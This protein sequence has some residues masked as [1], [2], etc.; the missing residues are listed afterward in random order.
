MGGLMLDHKIRLFLIVILLKIATFSNCGKLFRILI[1]INSKNAILKDKLAAKP[2]I[3]CSSTTKCKWVHSMDLR[4][5]LFLL[6]NQKVYKWLTVIKD[7]KNYILI[8]FSDL[9]NTYQTNC[10]TKQL[11]IQK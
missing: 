7:L 9:I 5:S 3:G 4:Y 10:Y 1:L 2:F 6:S 11:F 8:W